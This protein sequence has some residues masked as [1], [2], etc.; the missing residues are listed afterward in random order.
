MSDWRSYDEI[1]ERYDP[2]WSARFEPVARRIWALAPPRAGDKVLDIGTGT[3][4]VPMTLCA[5]AQKPGLV[6][7][8]DRS[9]GMLLRARARLAG[10]QVLVADASG[11][12]FAGESFDLATASFVLSHVRD[13]RRALREVQRVLKPS[14]RFAASNW[15]PPTDPYGAAWNECLAGAISKQSAERAMAEVA[16]WEAYFSQPGQL[17]SAVA[18]AGFS[19]VAAEVAEFEFAFT[20]EQYLE[21]RELSSGGRLGRHLLGPDGWARLLARAGELFQRRFGSSFSYPRRALIVIGRK[22]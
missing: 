10:L 2:V 14:G 21:D 11:L 18:Q 5:V 4:I 22:L 7:G 13:Y 16:P 9:Q 3:G 1:A 6:V 8:C 19:V 12:P 17:E 15:A 20:V